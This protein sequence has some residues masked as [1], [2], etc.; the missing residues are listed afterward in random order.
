MI[1]TLLAFLSGTLLFPCNAVDMN[2]DYEINGLTS[3]LARKDPCEEDV[4]FVYLDGI[5]RSIFVEI[6]DP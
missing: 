2:Q 3:V 1:Q 6:L 4:D 5:S